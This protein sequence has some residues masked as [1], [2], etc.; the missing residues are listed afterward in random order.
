[1]MVF[2]QPR[3]LGLVNETCRQHFVLM[4]QRLTSA[5]RAEVEADLDSLQARLIDPLSDV[6]NS[7]VLVYLLIAVGVYF[8]LRTRFI[9][10][11]YFGRMFRQL[12]RP[13]PRRWDLFQAFCVG[14]ASRVGTGNIAGVAIAR[15]PPS[16]PR[17]HLLD[18]GGGPGRHG[19]RP[20]RGDARSAVQGP[21]G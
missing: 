11:R 5:R 17:C 12:H 18:V 4:I 2:L 8:T 3:H 6:L 20:H 21:F 7:H 1:M 15:S 13:P 16:A 14:L 19:H 10:I 9:Q